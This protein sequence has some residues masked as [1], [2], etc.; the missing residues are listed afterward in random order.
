MGSVDGLA[1]GALVM[2]FRV[3]CVDGEAVGALV[4]AFDL[5]GLRFDVGDFDFGAAAPLVSLT[6]GGGG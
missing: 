1:V 6:V 2:A 4:L 5:A 3:G